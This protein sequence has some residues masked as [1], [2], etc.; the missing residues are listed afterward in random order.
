MGI[1]MKANLS[2]SAPES[3]ICR[4]CQQSFVPHPKVKDR[5]KVCSRRECQRLRQKLNHQAWLG[6]NP[7]DYR[8]WYADYG[9]PWQMAHPDYQRHY[10]KRQHSEPVSEPQQLLNSPLPSFS[11]EKKEELSLFLLA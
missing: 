7:V 10:R 9:K 4:L 3:R 2:S 1:A 11:L 6:K 5:Q 8:Q